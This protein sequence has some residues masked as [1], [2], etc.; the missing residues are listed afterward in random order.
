VGQEHPSGHESRGWVA[1][2]FGGPHD[3]RVTVVRQ[4]PPGRYEYPIAPRVHLTD[5]SDP[6]WPWIGRH[7]Y[8]VGMVDYLTHQ[9][10]LLYCGQNWSP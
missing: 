4:L 5:P 7:I 2:H 10:A 1:T 3:G 9:V 8:E 6:P